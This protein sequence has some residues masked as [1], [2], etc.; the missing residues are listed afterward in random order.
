VAQ[1]EGQTVHSNIVVT[2]EGLTGYFTTT[3]ARGNYTLSS[4][5]ARNKRFTLVFSRPDYTPFSLANVTV[6]KDTVTTLTSVKLTSLPNSLGALKERT[7]N[8]R[9]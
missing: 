4:V 1:L 6:S 8:T 2:V 7:I 5:P 3:D 9:R